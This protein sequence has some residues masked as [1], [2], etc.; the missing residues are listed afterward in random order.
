[1]AKRFFVLGCVFGFLGVAGGAFAAHALRDHL[2]AN[3]L[4]VFET[5]IRYQ[6]YHAFA[7]LAAAWALEKYRSRHFEWAGWAFVAGVALF[8][9]SLYIMAV[10]GIRWIGIITPFGG[11]AFLGGWA[12]MAA[13]FWKLQ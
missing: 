13:G 9:G 6:M 7:L 11:V 10:T 2:P 12:F 8:S 5:G 3:L 1:M 4:N